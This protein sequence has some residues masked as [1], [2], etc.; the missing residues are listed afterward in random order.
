MPLY[1]FR[2]NH[3]RYSGVLDDGSELTDR[4]AIW[5]KITEVCADLA[6]GICLCLQQDSE[7]QMELLDESKT[8]SFRIRLEAETLDLRF[9][10]RV[11]PNFCSGGVP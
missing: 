10:P 8:P 2:I 3:S 5:E 7:W 6:P 4:N 11:V 9:S 1:F